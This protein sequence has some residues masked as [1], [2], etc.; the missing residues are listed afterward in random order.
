MSNRRPYE[1]RKIRDAQS[2]RDLQKNFSGFEHAETQCRN[3][4][5][6]WD[7]S[8]LRRL[9]RQI[10]DLIIDVAKAPPFRRVVSFNDRMARGV[11]VGRRVPVWRVITAADVTAGPTESKVDPH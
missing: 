1:R 7:R 4:I 2:D 10:D 3:S 11:K 6:S 8:K 5:K 9:I